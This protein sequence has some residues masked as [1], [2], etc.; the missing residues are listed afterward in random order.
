VGDNVVLPKSSSYTLDLKLLPGESVS[1][2]AA[3]DVD[4]FEY[5]PQGLVG[6]SVDSVH[7]DATYD[8]GSGRVC[9]NIV[10]K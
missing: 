1:I 9:Y 6:K 2:Q 8:L 5:T 4:V 3:T 10:R 7:V